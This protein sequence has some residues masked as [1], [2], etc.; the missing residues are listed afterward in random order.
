M[1][2]NDDDVGS[3]SKKLKTWKIYTRRSKDEIQRRRRAFL[4]GDV[5]RIIGDNPGVLILSGVSNVSNMMLEMLLDRAGDVVEEID[6][7][8]VESN[9][10]RGLQRMTKL[11]Q[12]KTHYQW[13][14][15]SSR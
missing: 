14:Q 11:P 1:S 9:I 3:L 5:E 7:N 15:L 10:S 2:A 4:E 13:C 12:L 8:G 6:V